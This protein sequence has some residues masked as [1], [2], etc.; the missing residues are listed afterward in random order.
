MAVGPSLNP[1]R[2]RSR[3]SG[4]RRDAAKP[5]RHG[6]HDGVRIDVKINLGAA[7][8]ERPKAAAMQ[9]LEKKAEGI[10]ASIK[11]DGDAP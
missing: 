1:T 5:E 7:G 11:S 6:S 10:G 8:R 9:R 3:A 2:G 4:N